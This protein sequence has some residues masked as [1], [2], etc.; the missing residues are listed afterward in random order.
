[1]SRH[2]QKLYAVLLRDAFLEADSKHVGA[3]LKA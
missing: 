3:Y 2:G 1:M